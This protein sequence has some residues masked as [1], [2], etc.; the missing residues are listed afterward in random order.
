MYH[1][2]T[3]K[4]GKDGKN[5]LGITCFNQF[6]NF[7]VTKVV[8]ASYSSNPTTNT[9]VSGNPPKS[10]SEERRRGP[11]KNEERTRTTYALPRSEGG[12]PTW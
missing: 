9:Q 5:M 10:S 7:H 12:S 2:N 1:P 6:C 3:I 4:Q 11:G 8:S